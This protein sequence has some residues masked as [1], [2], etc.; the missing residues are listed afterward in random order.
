[1]GK[2]SGGKNGTRQNNVPPEFNEVLARM[3]DL[4]RELGLRISER[5]SG[6]NYLP[7]VVE[8]GI[9]HPNEGIG[10]YDTG[11]GVEI[12]LEPFREHD[13]DDVADDFM[14]VLE[15]IKGRKPARRRPALP[16]HVVLENWTRARHEVV[17]PYF[18]ARIA[19]ATEHR[20]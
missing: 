1:M 11:R 19:Q 3:D 20:G 8:E 6:W 15:V 4:A 9:S 5:P 7:P 16:C 17:E 18:Q 2:Q 10:V 14:A 12:N 13:R